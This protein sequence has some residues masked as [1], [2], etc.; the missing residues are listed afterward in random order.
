MSDGTDFSMGFH[1][2]GIEWRADAIV[3]Y[4]DG[5][6]YHTETSAN[7]YS[8]GAPGNGR[9]PVDQHFH[10]LV[11]VA[12]GGNFPGPPDGAA[13]FPQEMLVDWVRVYGLP[14]GHPPD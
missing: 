9:A 7:W 1:T 5:V 4:V 11:N 8:D 2:F 13:T 10:L 14:G 6:P 12:V 3:W